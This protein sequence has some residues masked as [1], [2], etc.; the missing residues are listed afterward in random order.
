ML[1]EQSIHAMGLPV[2]IHAADGHTMDIPVI[3]HAADGHTM[4]I[5]AISHVAYGHAME[6]PRAVP[7]WIPVLIHASTHVQIH[8]RIRVMD[9]HV[10]LHRAS[11]PVLPVISPRAQIPAGKPVRVRPAGKPV[12]LHVLRHVRSPVYHEVRYRINPFLFLFLK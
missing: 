1:S 5:P 9:G 10:M 7:V 3:I 8:A 2:I 6:Q 4:D 11:R 12:G